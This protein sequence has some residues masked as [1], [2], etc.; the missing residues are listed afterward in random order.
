LTPRSARRLS[1]TNRGLLPGAPVPTGAGLPPAS[2]VQLAG[3]NTRKAYV[4]NPGP[5]RPGY[6]QPGPV[7]TAFAPE[8]FSGDREPQASAQLL[9]VGRGVEITQRV[10]LAEPQSAGHV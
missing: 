1:T 7:S 3:R 10:G 2:P 9:L 5:A 8:C 4:A 6:P